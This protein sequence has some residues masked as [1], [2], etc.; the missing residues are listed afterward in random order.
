MALPKG[1]SN[2][3]ILPEKLSTP[4][5]G[6]KQS[7]VKYIGERGKAKQVSLSVL[8]ISLKLI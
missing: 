1:N 5:K 8:L 6:N 2:A 7:K 4:N 3:M